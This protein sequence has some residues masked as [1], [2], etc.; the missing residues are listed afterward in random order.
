MNPL[1]AWCYRWNIPAIA[2][3][4][5]RESLGAVGHPR[6]STYS[7][8]QTESGVQQRVRLHAAQQGIRAWR[9]NTGVLFNK[10]GTPVR[11]GLCNDTKAL[12]SKL[13]SS[14]LIGIKPITIIP[15]HVGQTLGQFYAREV[16]APG[17]KYT[18]SEREQAQLNF[19]F[20]QNTM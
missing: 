6:E 11:Y 14:D 5:L 10:A 15:A 19:Q 4:D 17:W 7:D 16:K 18:G 20:I 12:N 2:L 8:A 13:K 1:Y 3:D 9:N